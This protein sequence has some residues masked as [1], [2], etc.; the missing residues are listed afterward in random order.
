MA[1]ILNRHGRRQL[2]LMGLLILLVLLE[3]FATQKGLLSRD[4]AE[5]WI[6]IYGLS[7]V[8]LLR[9]GFQEFYAPDVILMSA[10]LLLLGI[11]SV[12][13]A[14]IRGVQ[15]WG[16][17]TNLFGI[18]YIA[19]W[20]GTIVPRVRLIPVRIGR[21]FEQPDT[22]RM[23]TEFLCLILF[24]GI[25]VVLLFMVSGIPILSGNVNEAKLQ[26]F[27]GK[28]YL[29]IFYRGL[30]IISAAYCY[31]A[32]THGSPKLRLQSHV[33][34]SIVVF[35][36]LL[37]G[38]RGTMLI[39]CATY[40]SLFSF[41]AG[42]RPRPTILIVAGCL[43]V[44]FLGFVGAYRRH[45]LSVAGAITELGIVVT[46][47]PA[48]SD[49]IMRHF[50]PSNYYEGSR[51]FDD[52]AK[53]LPGSQTGANVDLKY[54]LF[55]N[56]ANMP[57]LAGITPGLPAESF[58]NFGP[59]WIP[60]SLFLVGYASNLAFAAMKSAPTVIRSLFYF[61]LVFNLAGAV[62][63]GIATKVIHFVFIW[64]WIA[65]IAI[66]FRWKLKWI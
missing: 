3:W 39:F 64:F 40:I 54:Q 30:P 29:S 9:R 32:L 27:S 2:I 36:L 16:Y 61:T 13:Y 50:G 66:F 5:I 60:L 20:I 47:R 15:Y 10:Y 45:N 19:L 4:Y 58:M 38:Y 26:F 23:R 31:Y 44:T 49:N 52:L 17:S 12:L 63:S 28:G 65:V 7:L 53:L 43:A 33:L 51:Y 18:G 48:I 35:V 55:A 6:G 37:T 62:Q 25:A 42:W 21:R 46:A 1:T 41:L 56:A 8:Y 14:Y 22:L 24:A 11:G 34:A 59:W 57:E